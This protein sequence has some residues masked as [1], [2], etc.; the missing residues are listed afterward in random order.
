MD[1]TDAVIPNS[2]YRMFILEFSRH[3]TTQDMEELK[4]AL[5]IPSGTA[6]GLTTNLQ[7]FKYLERIGIVRPNDLRKLGILF[8]SMKRYDLLR[9]MIGTLSETKR[10]S[11]FSTFTNIA[12]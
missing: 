11:D 1:L 10:E 3:F 12:L 4:Y 5:N 2:N 8:I 6:E 9:R 7:V